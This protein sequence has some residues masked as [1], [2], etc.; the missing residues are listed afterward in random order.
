MIETEQEMRRVSWPTSK[1][2]WNATI[3]VSFVSLLLAVAM[4]SFD[5]ILR[6]LFHL[7]F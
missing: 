2:V 3:V 1:E 4:S 5:W 6:K 7:V